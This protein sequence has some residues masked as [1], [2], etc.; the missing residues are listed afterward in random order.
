MRVPPLFRPR[1]AD[2]VRKV[3]ARVQRVKVHLLHRVSQVFPEIDVPLQ[4]VLQLVV[5]GGA[6][7]D[8]FPAPDRFPH[9]VHDLVRGAVAQLRPRLAHR[10]VLPLRVLNQPLRRQADELQLA[11]PLEVRPVPVF[12]VDHQVVHA[13]ERVAVRPDVEQVF[14]AA[15]DVQHTGMLDRLKRDLLLLVPATAARGRVQVLHLLAAT[16][17]SRTAVVRLLVG[18]GRRPRLPCCI[19]SSTGIVVAIRVGTLCD[20]HHV[21]RVLPVLVLVQSQIDRLAL[22]H[23]DDEPV[24][25]VSRLVVPPNP[26]REFLVRASQFLIYDPA[27]FPEFLLDLF[28][29]L[30]DLR[31]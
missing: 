10:V 11:G 22:D 24:E 20:L 1:A 15:A 3:V 18:D 2:V 21:V 7:F 30:L 13:R 8:V 5:H 26:R 9:R 27:R 4:L 19:S 31:V 29:H 14:E 28:G 25:F 23:A 17:A 16:T 12:H 6:A